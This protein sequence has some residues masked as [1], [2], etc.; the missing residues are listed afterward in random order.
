MAIITVKKLPV[1]ALMAIP[2]R[3]VSSI[4]LIGLLFAQPVLA[5]E[6][7]FVPSVNLSETYTDNVR[8]L[9]KGNDESSFITQASP[10]FSLT[11]TGSQLKLHADYAMQNLYYS[12]DSAGVRTNHILNATAN[13]ELIRG[14]FFLDGSSNISQQNSS[15][16]QSAAADNLNLSN[17]RVEVR[18]Y[19]VSPYFRKNFDNEFSSE[20]R[21][22]RSS[23]ATSVQNGLDSKAD[24]LQLS[25]NSGSA[26]KTVT[27]GLQYN[28]Q[29]IHYPQQSDV[30][31]QTTT[32]NAS[33]F[34]SPLFA[35]T[36]TAGYEDNNYKT[37]GEKP[38]GYF[39][40]GG[41]A[42]TP[43]ERTKLAVSAGKRFYGSTYSLTANQRT[44]GSIWSL[45]YNEDITTTRGQ[46]LVAASVNTSDF[47][48]QLWK[49]SVPDNA[50]RQQLIDN[51]IKDT[52]LP[53]S[54]SQPVNTITNR[55]FLQKSLQG[56]VALN[57]A[58]NTVIFNVFRIGREAQSISDVDV[59]LL[60][61]NDPS[62]L[63]NTRQTGANV[64]WNWQ[65]SSRTNAN[66]SATFTRVNSLATD[67]KDNN[68]SLRASISR[69][70]Q[71]KLRATLEVRR[72]EKQ[73][74]L[75]SNSFTENAVT[76][77]LLLGF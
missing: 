53:A 41:F 39:W 14:L 47:L 4:P 68:K 27:W 36:A 46:Y 55:V 63:D 35:I 3:V 9:P 50:A 44:R 26:F 61:A 24:Q 65:L 54:L 2:S 60:G 48:N 71:A 43:T 67:I 59:A 52:N 74:T 66:V 11:A 8:L 51:F 17:N 10:G 75:S 62:L 34:I 37:T 64:V 77:F 25:A 1:S 23:V 7:K 69:Q 76:L 49:A 31:F 19:S 16:F 18:T 20:L 56:S 29:K 21:Y 15:P 58:R 32:A 42:W 38:S 6:W 12:S 30:T 70:L 28:D 73:S 13:S 57:G 5:A 33:Y 40:S 22:T 45:G 72:V